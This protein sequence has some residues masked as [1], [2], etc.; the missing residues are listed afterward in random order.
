MWYFMIPQTKLREYLLTYLDKLM[1]KRKIAILYTP[2]DKRSAKKLI[3]YRQPAILSAD[4]YWMT[5]SAT[6]LSIMYLLP[7]DDQTAQQ[8]NDSIHQITQMALPA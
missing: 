3:V 8:P 7:K 2:A 5:I 4:F 1:T 6:F